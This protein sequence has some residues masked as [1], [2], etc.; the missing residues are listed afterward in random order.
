MGSTGRELFAYDPNIGATCLVLDVL[1]GPGS[2]S[3]TRIMPLDSTGQRFVMGARTSES[4]PQADVIVVE[5]RQTPRCEPEPSDWTADRSFLGVPMLSSS[6]G[7]A[8]LSAAKVQTTSAHLSAWPGPFEIAFGDTLL[9]ADENSEHGRELWM[10]PLLS[11]DWDSLRAPPDLPTLA[12]VVD[13]VPG[14]ESSSP[15]SFITAFP[16][17][18]VFSASSPARGR[19]LYVMQAGS[20]PELLFEAATGTA[21][22]NPVPLAIWRRHL[23]VAA[24]DGKKQSAFALPAGARQEWM[25]VAD[26]GGR[27]T[28]GWAESRQSTRHPCLFLSDRPGTIS[29][30]TLELNS[31]RLRFLSH[32]TPLGSDMCAQIVRPSDALVLDSVDRAQSLEFGASVAILPRSAMLPENVAGPASGILGSPQDLEIVSAIEQQGNPT[33]AVG[34][35]GAFP[36]GEI[37]LWSPM[38]ARSTQRSRSI[39]GALHRQTA[40]LRHSPLPDGAMLGSVI[41]AGSFSP[42]LQRTRQ[43]YTFASDGDTSYGQMSAVSGEQGGFIAASALGALSS[44]SNGTASNQTSAPSS[45]VDVGAVVVF[46]LP[47]DGRQW[48]FRQIIAP[49]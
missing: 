29:P 38:Q 1:P 7:F 17:S 10:A 37:Q 47:R 49:P 30:T 19:E 3:P 36:S 21:S 28:M 5:F 13:I 48:E 32:T 31:I 24:F 33:I 45:I 26:S 34:V 18:V 4:S 14:A 20:S 9:F 12:T 27:T 42:S 44:V 39:A 23:I 41:A 22:S 40:A 6:G 11:L 16:D 15:T 8:I 2:S 46:V 35:P 43:G 25:H